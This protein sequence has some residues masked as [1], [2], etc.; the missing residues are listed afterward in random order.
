MLFHQPIAKV[1]L[2]AISGISQ[3]DPARHPGGK[4]RCDL[5]ARDLPLV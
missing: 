4:R 1:R 5:R 3:Y 2:I